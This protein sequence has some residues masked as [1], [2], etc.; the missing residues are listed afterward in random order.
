M[1]KKLE[2]EKSFLYHR[3]LESVKE[4]E[5]PV[6]FYVNRATWNYIDSLLYERVMDPG[7]RKGLKL[8]KGYCPNH[9]WQVARAGDA[10]GISM[11][12]RDLVGLFQRETRVL[13]GNNGFKGPSFR[14]KVKKWVQGKRQKRLVSKKRICPLCDYQKDTEKLTLSS[15]A[16]YLRDEEFC[17]GYMESRGL[18]YPHF[19]EGLKMSHN[20]ER[21]AGVGRIGLGIKRVYS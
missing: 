4:A 9:A 15:I 17:K 14:E 7:T 8:A 12:Y 13:V 2:I 18:C 3:V 21:N 6:C 11:L 20:P 1:S 10:F 5:C 19:L 16:D